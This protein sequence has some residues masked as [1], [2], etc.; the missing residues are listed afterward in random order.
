MDRYHKRS[1]IETAYDTIKAG[2][3]VSYEARTMRGR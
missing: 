3:G 1:N 2:S